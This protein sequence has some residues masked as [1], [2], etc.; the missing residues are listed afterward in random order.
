ML[1]YDYC[2]NFFTIIHRY[3]QILP[4]DGDDLENLD[5][6]DIDNLKNVLLCNL[7]KNKLQGGRLT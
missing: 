2:N 7:I 3:T 5:L 1:N 4:E 6:V